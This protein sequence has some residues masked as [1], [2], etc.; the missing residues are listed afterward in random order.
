MVEEMVAQLGEDY[1][2]PFAEPVGLGFLEQRLEGRPLFPDLG[3]SPKLPSDPSLG[4]G[5]GE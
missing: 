2:S 1:R 4:R 3:V 5:D